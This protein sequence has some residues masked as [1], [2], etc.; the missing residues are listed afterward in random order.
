MTADDATLGVFMPAAATSGRVAFA[1][2]FGRVVDEDLIALDGRM[3]ADEVGGVD[4]TGFA[5][6]VAFTAGLMVGLEAEVEEAA[7]A[8]ISP[9][10]IVAIG[11]LSVAR[12]AV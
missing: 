12:R 8:A 7:E 3:G 4:F 6:A 11:C 1:A 5:P 10:L 9:A 2:D